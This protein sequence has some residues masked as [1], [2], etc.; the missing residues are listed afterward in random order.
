MKFLTK[1]ECTILRGMA[2]FGI[3]MHNFCHLLPGIVKEN[4]FTWKMSNNASF[5][6]SIQ[7][8]DSNLPID[9][10]SF[11]GHYGVAIFLFLSGFGLVM[12]YEVNKPKEKTWPFASSFIAYNWLKLTRLCVVGSASY[13]V[14]ISLTSNPVIFNWRTV[15]YTITMT[16]NL[17]GL[18]P[19]PGAFWF[20]GLMIQLYVVYCVVMYRFRHWSVCAVSIIFSLVL[21]YCFQSSSYA[22]TMIHLNFPGQ[23][24]AFCA[25]ILV[26]RHAKDVKVNRIVWLLIFLLSIT[27]SSILGM[28]FVGWMFV[29]LTI[30][31]GAIAFIRVLPQRIYAP[32]RWIGVVSAAVFVAH[33]VLRDLLLQ[34]YRGQDIYS[35][36]LVYAVA[37][38]AYS[39]LVNCVLKTLPMPRQRISAE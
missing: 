33:P 7:S 31:I 14:I 9:I 10:I 22:S 38:P 32:L 30:I 20:F 37:V 35:G 26:A 3:V 2:I 12:K 11:F 39:W 19:V 15:I 29:P 4:E 17:R 1:T 6:E 18:L 36:V 16:A 8:A 13:I 34:V 25:G 24:T 21:Q 23:L 27:L 28:S 5:L